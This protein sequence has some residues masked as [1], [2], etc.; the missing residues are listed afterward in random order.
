M[1][2]NMNVEQ[3]GITFSF[4][5]YK[6]EY[7]SEWQIREENIAKLK[8]KFSDNCNYLLKHKKNEEEKIKNLVKEFDEKFKGVFIKSNPENRKKYIEYSKK[9]EEKERLEKEKEE[10]EKNRRVRKY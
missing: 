10:R 2:M 4:G 3:D 9:Y 8:V 1:S 7:K 6:G 5:D